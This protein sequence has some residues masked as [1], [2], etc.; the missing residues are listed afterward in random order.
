VDRCGPLR[1]AEIWHIF[2]YGLEEQ[3][4]GIE[5]GNALDHDIRQE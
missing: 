4:I 5:L 1:Y 2:V 3:R